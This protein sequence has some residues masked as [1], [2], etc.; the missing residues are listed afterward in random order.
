MPVISVA[1]LGRLVGYI[2]MELYSAFR[3]V[4]GRAVH[5]LSNMTRSRSE[6][7]SAVPP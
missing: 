2:I 5:V 3:E 1:M 4:A 7:D 6:Y